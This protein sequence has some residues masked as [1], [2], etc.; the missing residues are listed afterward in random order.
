VS[1]AFRIVVEQDVKTPDS[2]HVG[3]FVRGREG[4]C[5]SRKHRWDGKR[6]AT[7]QEAEL[8]DYVKGLLIDVAPQKQPKD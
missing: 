1:K 4:S 3:L 8:I 6:F 2:Y 7:G 5:A